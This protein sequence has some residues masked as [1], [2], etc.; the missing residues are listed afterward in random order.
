MQIIENIFLLEL[1]LKYK[2]E[3]NTKLKVNSD[4]I[5]V[6]TEFDA[7]PTVVE[8]GLIY[9]NDELYFGL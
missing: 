2:T 3:G 9:M 4:G 7:F 6:F 1:R 5:L 8:G